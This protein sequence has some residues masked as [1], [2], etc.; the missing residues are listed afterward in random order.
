VFL[1]VAT[2]RQ[3]NRGVECLLFITIKPIERLP[4]RACTTIW[5][6]VPRSTPV[7]TP[8]TP[9]YIWKS[10]TRAIRRPKPE[11]PASIRESHNKPPN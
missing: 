10:T 4:I 3:E 9:Q 5:Q 8:P 6:Y 1:L 2:R 7:P 11:Y